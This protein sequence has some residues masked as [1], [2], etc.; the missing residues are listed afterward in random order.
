MF[1]LVGERVYS[2]A[3]DIGSFECALCG[4][5]EPFCHITETNYF[6]LFGIRLLKVDQYANYYRCERCGNS[7]LS[8][9]SLFTQSGR[10]GAECYCVYS[11]RLWQVRGDRSR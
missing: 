1:L 6:C 2:Q 9:S 3:Q 10:I 11:A 4:K 8:D 5:A 7:Y